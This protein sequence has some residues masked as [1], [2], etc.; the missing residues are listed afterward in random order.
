MV[1]VAP[2]SAGLVERQGARFTL[3]FGYLFCFLGFGTMFALW[4]DHSGTGRWG[5]ATPC[6]GSVSGSPALPH[7]IP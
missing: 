3:L 4:S 7:P 2:Q 1:L 5:S 6:L